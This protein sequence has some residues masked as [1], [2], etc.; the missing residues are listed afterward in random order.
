[1]PGVRDPSFFNSNGTNVI[2]QWP[3]TGGYYNFYVRTYTSTYHYAPQ[4]YTKQVFIEGSKDSY[5]TSN[6]PG[7]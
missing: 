1:M 3:R 7:L 6:K 5:I 4:W 2:K